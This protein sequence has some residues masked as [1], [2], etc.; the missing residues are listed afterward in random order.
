M[1][2]VVVQSKKKNSNMNGLN[3]NKI[4]E[5]FKRICM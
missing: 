1:Q 5:V 2:T 4:Q 3:L